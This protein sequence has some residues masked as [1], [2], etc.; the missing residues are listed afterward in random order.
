MASNGD[1]LAQRRHPSL[2]DAIPDL[3]LSL[4]M[5]LV[6]PQ[7]PFSPLLINENNKFQ[8]QAT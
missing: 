7:I 8:A 6:T 3:R 1:A 4:E 5:V 2:S